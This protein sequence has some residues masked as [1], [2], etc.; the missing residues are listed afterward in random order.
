[1]RLA[2]TIIQQALWRGPESSRYAGLS[3]R[4]RHRGVFG[5]VL[6]WQGVEKQEKIAPRRFFTSATL[7]QDDSRNDSAKASFC[8]PERQR[9]IYAK[10]WIPVPTFIDTLPGKNPMPREIRLAM[11]IE[12][13]KPPATIERTTLVTSFFTPLNHMAGQ[14]TGDDYDERYRF[15]HS[16]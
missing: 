6:E 15:N 8:H 16:K 3:V 13:D 4:S 12:S 9:R 11:R 2:L 14:Y 5:I 10:R 7:V 1:M